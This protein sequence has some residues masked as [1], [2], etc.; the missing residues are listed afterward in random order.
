MHEAGGW[1]TDDVEPGA[2]IACGLIPPI[3]GGGDGGQLGDEVHA[4]LV[5]RLPVPCGKQ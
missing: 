1:S 2:A 5:H 3:D 4:V